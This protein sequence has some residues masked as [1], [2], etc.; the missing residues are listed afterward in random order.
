[1]WFHDQPMEIGNFE[2]NKEAGRIP[3][4]L[5][6]IWYQCHNQRRRIAF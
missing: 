4:N 6:G 2:G 3:G 5:K 1:M